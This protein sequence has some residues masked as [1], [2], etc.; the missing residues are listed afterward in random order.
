MCVRGKTVPQSGFYFSPQPLLLVWPGDRI[1]HLL[2]RA[3]GRK[4]MKKTLALGYSVAMMAL[5]F[6]CSKSGSFLS[7]ASL[8]L[9]LQLREPWNS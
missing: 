8:T 1:H 7:Q 2:Q 9:A 5:G 4:H 6:A 3:A